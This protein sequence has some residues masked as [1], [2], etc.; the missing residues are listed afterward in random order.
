MKTSEQLGE[1]ATAMAKAQGAIQDAEKSSDNPFFKSKYADLAEVLGQI[2]PIFSANDLSLSQ[3]PELEGEGWV[4]CT[5]RVMHTSGQWME[6]TMSMPV[7]AKNVAQESG[8]VI[9][10][11]R[12]YMAAAVAGIAQVED[13]AN[14]AKSKGEELAPPT[15][16][17]GWYNS[18][19]QDADQIRSQL[20]AGQTPVQILTELRKSYKLARKV[21]DQVEALAAEANT[22]AN[23]PLEDVPF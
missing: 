10:Y 11:M 20:H 23:G 9:T 21:T 14:Q 13:D 16:T 17:K 5:T 22:P 1:L 2:R 3:W 7:Q 8:S 12:R 6:S 15:K 19:E 18:F 4:G